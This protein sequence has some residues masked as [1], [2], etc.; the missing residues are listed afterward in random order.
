MSP[1]KHLY[2][3]FPTAV[4]VRSLMIPY[5]VSTAPYVAY[6]YYFMVLG[7][8]VNFTSDQ[9]LARFLIIVVP[10]WSKVWAAE[11]KDKLL[12]TAVTAPANVRAMYSIFFHTLYPLGKSVHYSTTPHTFLPS[13]SHLKCP[14][15]STLS[16][17]IT[18]H[19]KVYLGWFPLLWSLSR[20]HCLWTLGGNVFGAIFCHQRLP[21]LVSIGILS[22]CSFKAMVKAY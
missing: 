14:S 22:N 9:F 13:L 20:P 17:G 4:S 11:V 21:N 6:L 10:C 16:D 15:F 5:I 12:R 2:I 7:H 3:S 1:F 19:L 18:S 8:P